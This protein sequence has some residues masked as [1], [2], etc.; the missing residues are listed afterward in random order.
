VRRDGS[1][2]PEECGHKCWDR[3]TISNHANSALERINRGGDIGDA[4]STEDA[5]D[6]QETD[7]RSP[8]VLEPRDVGEVHDVVVGMMREEVNELVRRRGQAR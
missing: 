5:T 8:R 6:D 7:E 2:V 4:V 3:S 1:C